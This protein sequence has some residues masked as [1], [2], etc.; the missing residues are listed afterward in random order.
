MRS[1]SIIN[2]EKPKILV[3]YLHL[4]FKNLSDD[5][6]K[7]L[8]INIKYG[9]N[10]FIDNKDSYTFRYIGWRNYVMIDVNCKIY[11]YFAM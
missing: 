4:L 9:N 11:I 6:I 2:F 10:I 8:P 1:T 3:S 5:Q 7:K